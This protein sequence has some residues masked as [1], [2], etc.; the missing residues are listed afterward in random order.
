M[1]ARGRE[2]PSGGGVC[3]VQQSVETDIYTTKETGD[4][5]LMCPTACCGLPTRYLE[6][7]NQ[8]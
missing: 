5:V 4:E 7:G 1:Q 6:R 3:S 8:H 2:K